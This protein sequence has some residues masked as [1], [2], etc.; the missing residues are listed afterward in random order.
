MTLM[1]QVLRSYIGLF[2]VV[3]FDDILIYSKTLSDHVEHLRKVLDVP[4]K[5]VLFAS[6]KKCSFGTYNLVF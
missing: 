3:Y 4:R 1:N 5:E 6:F 2:V